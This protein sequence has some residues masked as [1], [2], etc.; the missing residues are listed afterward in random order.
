M[1]KRPRIQHFYGQNIVWRVKWPRN[2]GN[3]GRFYIALPVVLRNGE[4]PREEQRSA[5]LAAMVR[6]ERHTPVMGARGNNKA[7]GEIKET[8]R[9]TVSQEG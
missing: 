5:G 2:A 3:P 7:R 4:M 1:A 6:T 8:V 9:I